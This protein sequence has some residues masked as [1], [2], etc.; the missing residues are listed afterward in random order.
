[1][2]DIPFISAVDVE[3]KLDWTAIADALAD[4]HQRGKADLGDLLLQSK[5]NAILNRAAWIDGKGIALKSMTIFPDNVRQDPPLPSVQGVVI[6]FDSENGSVRALIDGVLVTKWKT[7]GDSVLGARLLA[8]TD[9]QSLLI[10]G[11]GTVAKSLISAYTEMFPNLKRIEIWSR[12]P[13]NAEEL[14]SQTVINNV[15]I[16]S[17]VDLRRAAGRADIITCATMAHQ[18][19]LSGEWIV[20]GTHIDL[21]GAFTPDMREADDLLMQRAELFVDARETTI[22]H[23]GELMIPLASGT[24]RENDIRGDLYD[25]CTG[26]PGRS[27]PDAITLFK[28]GGGAH[29]DLLTALKIYKTY[30][31]TSSC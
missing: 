25:L 30:R 6:L 9:S 5:E 18:P 13:S 23:I 26:K 15:E 2:T 22:N 19:V 21:I 8:R 27:G 24:I 20:P 17:T 7:A 11:S 4:G 3:S 1:M 16:S 29:L 28:N 14:A 12:N 31:Q 10:V